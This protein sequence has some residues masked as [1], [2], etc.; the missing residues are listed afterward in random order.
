MRGLA[1]VGLAVGETGAAALAGFMAISDDESWRDAMGDLSDSTILL[2]VTEGV[3]DPD[4]YRSIVGRSP[5]E[6][7]ASAAVSKVG[8]DPGMSRPVLEEQTN[9]EP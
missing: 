9:K 8:C 5:A 6:V 2:L 1:D 4:A 3:T 7:H